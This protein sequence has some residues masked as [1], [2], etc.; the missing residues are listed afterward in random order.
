MKAQARKTGKSID[1]EIE[2]DSSPEQVWDAISQAEG[3][4]RWFPLDASVEAGQGG[5]MT[6]SWGPGCEGTAEIGVW[7]KGRRIQLIEGPAGPEST[8]ILTE[9]LIE[10][11][12]GKTVLRLVNSGFAPGEDWADYIE[13]LDSGWRYFLW[14]LNTIW[15][16][17]RALRGVWSGAGKS[18]PWPGRK[19]GSGCWAPA[20]WRRLPIPQPPESR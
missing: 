8:P 3:L 18:Q 6:W 5:S 20:G 16:D 11:R 9:F 17:I 15:N 2:I 7:E 10:S 4:K 14:N 12:A 19:L 13:T 1:L